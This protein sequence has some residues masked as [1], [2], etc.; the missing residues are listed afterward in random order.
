MA[1][2]PRYNHLDANNTPD[3]R[4]APYGE[5]DDDSSGSIRSGELQRTMGPFS[6]MTVIAGMIIGSGIFSTP[7]GILISVGSVG[8]SLFIWVI[9]AVASFC[10]VL[11]YLELGSM[12]PRSGGEKEYLDY[13]YEKPKAL[14]PFLFCLSMIVLTRGGACAVD[15]V[16]TGTYL[17]YAGGIYNNPWAERG[18]GIVV[19]TLICIL[20]SVSVK[21]GIRTTDI[22]TLLKII[23]L[24]IVAITGIVAAA[25]GTS[26]PPTHAFTNAFEGTRS[27]G[28][29]YAVALFKASF[30]FDGWN[31]ANY[32]IG[33]LRDPIRTLRIASLSAISVVSVLYVLA[34]VAYF[35]V[36]PK[37][38]ILN[39]NTVV[40][41]EFF[42]RVFGQKAGGQALPV[43][44]AI[45]SFGSTCAMTFT[46][47][48]VIMEA[49][50]EGY[51]PY[52]QF[53]GRV[54]RFETPAN[55]FIIHWV[56][57][58]ILMLAP[59]AGDSYNFIV[60]LQS[61]PEW[62]FYGASVVGLV[63][64]RF[65]Q[66]AAPRPFK[67]FWIT[68]IFFILVAIFLVIAPFVPPTIS[69][70]PSIP[71]YIVPVVSVAFI[72][73]SG[74]L[75]F[76]RVKLFH[77]LETSLN[78][79]RYIWDNNLYG[80]EYTTDEIERMMKLANEEELARVRHRA[81]ELARNR[82]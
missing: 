39:S 27:D 41:A 66:P 50:R 48:R 33:E 54:S 62:W 59:P 24:V 82:S 51:L 5:T 64:L 19:I 6:A 68:N 57:T 35:A 67:S 75:W 16:V 11:A 81:G 45:S 65:T 25:G 47:G 42:T 49:A 30:A 32:V 8:M 72:I 78:V 63:I 73:L 70:T 10:G 9:A 14:A 28:N 43:L 44:I 56:V 40:A 76:I 69:D 20:H 1:E 53:F 3:S 37:E 17:L 29:G 22:L 61:Y 52:G 26:A 23:V 2:D 21:W 79:Q 18:I 4:N 80:R 58:M 34:N 74:V 12:L 31:N 60:N 55:A 7:S 71:Y 36:V 77:G 46:A 13:E 38:V 15:S